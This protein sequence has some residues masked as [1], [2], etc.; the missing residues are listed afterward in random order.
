MAKCSVPDNL[1]CLH[2]KDQNTEWEEILHLA[3]RIEVS[4]G[5]MI[6]T[7][8]QK[9]FYYIQRGCVRLERLFASGDGQTALF[10]EDGSFCAEIPSILF[11]KS[12]PDDSGTF[13]YAQ[14]NSVLYRFSEELLAGDDF[15]K[16]YPHLIMSLLRS[17][18]YKSALLLRNGASNLTLTPEERIS[19][20]LIHLVKK[21][22]GQLCFNP[23][24][25]QT[26]LGTALG[27]PRS[28]FC[29]AIAH[30]RTK[31]ALGAFTASRVEILDF[32]ML[33]MIASV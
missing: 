23:K 6:P 9:G 11:G 1:I 24:M 4:R 18:A 10:F 22:N 32:A 21:A 17:V 7:Q 31:G 28:T 19:R 5:S 12:I 2:I 26:D 8:A 27:I 29:R 25:S 20:Y 16:Q 3:T 30:L 15:A 14:E 13:F 33:Q